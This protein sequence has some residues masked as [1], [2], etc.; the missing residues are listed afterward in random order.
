MTLYS[1]S[2]RSTSLVFVL[3]FLLLFGVFASIT[4]P[5]THYPYPFPTVSLSPG[6]ALLTAGDQM[7]SWVD[8]PL[9]TEAIGYVIQLRSRSRPDHDD[10]TMAQKGQGK[11]GPD[12]APSSSSSLVVVPPSSSSSSSSSLLLPWEFYLGKVV[13]FDAE[14]QT[15]RVQFATDADNNNDR[16][17]APPSSSSSSAAAAA[18]AA[19]AMPTTTITT[20]MTVP[21][22]MM[23]DCEDVPYA[24]S[25]IAW[26]LPPMI[27]KSQVGTPL[28]SLLLPPPLPPLTHP[29]THL[30]NPPC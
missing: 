29:S 8:R 25:E 19:L 21:P 17:I 4:L 13:G 30:L 7:I 16:Q 3:T 22:T 6:H 24:S 23:S 27:T 1:R 12:M 18:A 26:M 11:G 10:T 2:I 9:L 20:A 28:P 14:K 5:L 15:I